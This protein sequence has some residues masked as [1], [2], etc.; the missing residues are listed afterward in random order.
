MGHSARWRPG[1]RSPQAR[2]SQEPW[3]AG[4]LALTE[5]VAV[6]LAATLASQ[7]ASPRLRK[8]LSAEQAELPIPPPPEVRTQSRQ[9]LSPTS[10]PSSPIASRRTSIAPRNSSPG[11]QPHGLEIAHM[12]QRDQAAR[13]RSTS[14]SRVAFSAELVRVFVLPADRTQ[15]AD[16]GSK[17]APASWQRTAPRGAPAPMQTSAEPQPRIS[18]SG[19]SAP[20]ARLVRPS[21][22]RKVSN[23]ADFEPGRLQLGPPQPAKQASSDTALVRQG[24]SGIPTASSADAPDPSSPGRSPKGLQEGTPRGSW[25]P[26]RAGCCPAAASRPA[27]SPPAPPPTGYRPVLVSPGGLSLGSDWRPP[28]ARSPPP[29]PPASSAASSWATRP[30]RPR[31][32]PTRVLH[33]E[34]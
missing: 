16:G 13:P 5:P 29:A 1:S 25:P 18:G 30:D 28:A 33:G 23:A 32:P 2:H 7:P 26:W 21:P 4:V 27:G 34:V 12:I 20:S 9:R 19:P 11:S 22:L 6:S 15:V 3:F 17:T 8:T 10:G 24:P 14:G 31:A